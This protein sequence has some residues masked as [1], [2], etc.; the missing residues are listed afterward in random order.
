ML[1]EVFI[2]LVKRS[3]ITQREVRILLSC[4]DLGEEISGREDPPSVGNLRRMIVF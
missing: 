4:S 3:L 1:C 2:C